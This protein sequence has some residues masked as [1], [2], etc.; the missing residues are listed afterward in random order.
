MEKFIALATTYIATYNKIPEGQV[1]ADHAKFVA[2]HLKDSMRGGGVF[3]IQYL[4]IL[5]AKQIAELDHFLD[6]KPG[7]DK[8]ESYYKKSKAPVVVTPAPKAVP[9]TSPKKVVVTKKAP[10]VAGAKSNKDIAIELYQ[11]NK[12]LE[13]KHLVSLFISQMGVGKNTATTYAY[14]VRKVWV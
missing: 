2:G 10:K 11:A 4:E 8:P 3:P 13:P 6:N 1:D 14:N 5:S 12:N 7:F 9:K